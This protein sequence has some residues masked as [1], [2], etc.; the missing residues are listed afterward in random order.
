MYKLAIALAGFGS[1]LLVTGCEWSAGGS[2]SGYNSRYN[3]VNFNGVYRSIDGGPLV[4]DYSSAPSTNTTPT[5]TTYSRLNENIGTQNGSSDFY[6]GVLSYKPV[7]PGTLT[8]R[9]GAV[10]LTDNGSGS[11][12]GGG[13][14]GSI[15]YNTGSWSVDFNLN[16]EPAGTPIRAD[17]DYT[18]S[19]GGG[20]GS[21]G[22][23]ASGFVIHSFVLTHQGENLEIR[24]NNGATYSGKLGS[25]AVNEGSNAANP[26]AVGDLISM[27]YSASG[28]S[29]A[30]KSVEIVGTLQAVVSGVSSNGSSVKLAQR[31]IVGTWIEQNGKTG[32]VEGSSVT[33]TVAG[34]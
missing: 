24:D 20:T 21:S 15:N 16:I 1:W 29:K 8:I 17:Y 4:T 9:S 10:T 22:S 23:G 28:V 18:V 14:T 2:D 3:W 30:G 13:A 34:P 7:V 26:P 31:Q 12:S 33:V 32:N 25:T 27:Q 5:G 6:S 19:S 11:L